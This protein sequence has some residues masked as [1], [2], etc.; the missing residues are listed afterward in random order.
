MRELLNLPDRASTKPRT[1]GLTNVID[2]GLTIDAARA[3][4]SDAAP[5]IDLVK[6]GW[7]TSLVTPRLGE[8]IAVFR[9]HDIDVCMGGTL[10][11]IAYSQGKID[12]LVAWYSDLGLTCVEISNGSIH[13]EASEKTRCI[14]LF[15]KRFKV[16]SEVGD[17]DQAAVVSPVKWQR[18][19]DRDLKA[20]ATYVILEGRETGS[21]GMYRPSGEMRIGLIDEI[22]EKTPVNQ[23]I[24]EAPTKSSQAQ[25]IK[26]FGSN[27]NL[28]NIPPEEVIALETLRLGLRSDTIDLAIGHR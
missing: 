5:F 23:L 11:E 15:A 9:S 7:S 4:A 28:G 18:E 16:Y 8:K 2:K 17:K 25:L 22:L 20:G 14:E 19:I 10:F 24:F 21:A 6:L 13:L 26:M 1:V 12:E 27:V 3:M